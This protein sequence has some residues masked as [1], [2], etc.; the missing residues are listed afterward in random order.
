[1]PTVTN[2]DTF[3]GE[4]NLQDSQGNVNP[5]V[6]T[7]SNNQQTTTSDSEQENS[8]AANPA[9]TDNQNDN[10]KSKTAA[11]SDATIIPNRIDNPES[12]P[13]VVVDTQSK[14]DV[15]EP[16]LPI[17]G[18][19]LSSFVLSIIAGFIIFLV[20]FLFVKEFDATSSIKIPT[21]TNISDSTYV[22]KIE[23]IKLIQEEKKSYRDFIIQIS[24]M[25]LLN[26]LLPVLTAILG[27]IFA[28]NK[29][30]ES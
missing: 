29:N 23:L 6:N 2:S 26:L 28:S 1:M 9:A 5:E 16:S 3:G 17:I 11:V 13:S 15:K 18:F 14:P 20:A 10:S 24:Q 7:Q 12:L 25:V 4:Q 30:K 19:N 21:E 27:Y 22:M 8:N